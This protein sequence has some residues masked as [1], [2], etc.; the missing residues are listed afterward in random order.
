[1]WYEVDLDELDQEQYYTT[2]ISPEQTEELVVF[3]RLFLYNR[4]LPCG[5]AV[6]RKRLEEHYC[7]R[8]LPSMR[9]IGA[10]LSRNGLTYG[11][12][13]NYPGEEPPENRPED[14]MASPPRYSSSARRRT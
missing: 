4:G 9:R 13:G 3:E 7:V 14:P 8:P 12:T 11:R 10:I 1:M 2:V 6:L 5:A